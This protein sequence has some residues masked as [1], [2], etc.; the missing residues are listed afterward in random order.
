MREALK[1]GMPE[2]LE[3]VPIECIHLYEADERSNPPK[4]YGD[5]LED[6]WVLNEKGRT[7]VFVDWPQHVI[8]D[9]MTK[10]QKCARDN[11]FR[12]DPKG[13]G[14][15]TDTDEPNEKLNYNWVDDKTIDFQD[16]YDRGFDRGFDKGHDKGYDLGW[17]AGH[18]K[19]Y[20]QRA[21]L[22]T[23]PSTPSSNAEKS[24]VQAGSDEDAAGSGSGARG[25]VA[26][27]QGP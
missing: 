19:G 14:Y 11:L 12:G 16:A 3:G 5:E 18:S 25:A 21:A 8:K 27:R 22:A 23:K 20:A 15:Y 24:W 10:S 6:N 26:S 7:M 13:E 9:R 4:K 2:W 1:E 17:K